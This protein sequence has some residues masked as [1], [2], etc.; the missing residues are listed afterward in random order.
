MKLLFV[1]GTGIISSSCVE[2]AKARG[3]HV[4]VLN[5]GTSRGTEGVEAIVSDV[6]DLQAARTALG[7]RRWDVIVD[8]T[9]FRREEALSRIELLADR[10]DQYVFISSASAYQKPVSHYVITEKT[11]LQNPFWDYAREK[12]AC[13][14]I[15]LEANKQGRLPVTIVRPSLTYGPTHVPLVLNSWQMPYTLIDR[16]RR[17]APVIVPGDGASLWSITHSEDFAKGMIGL[18]GKAS[19]VGEDFH[20]TT[21]EVLTWDQYFKVTAA[22]AGAEEPNIVHIASDFI[23]TCLPDKEGSLL[24]DKAVSVVFDNRKIKRFVPGFEASISFAEGIA[25]SI[26]NMDADESL[27]A[28]DAAA[29]QV[30]DK[31]IDAYQ[32]GLEHAK[33]SFR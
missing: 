25:K 2:L 22:A 11:P 28:V 15:F 20:I 21:D 18:L 7:E 27:R 3:N 32:F 16:M 10:C 9:V 29:N 31:L 33:R 13:E 1:G 14:S 12:A 6:N 4:T 17:G 8:F 19:A 26:R 5:R 30:Y 23:S 24:G